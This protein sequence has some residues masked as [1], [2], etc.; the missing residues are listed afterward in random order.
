MFFFFLIRL[1]LFWRKLLILIILVVSLSI[2]LHKQA[3]L[4]LLW[5]KFFVDA[6]KKTLLWIEGCWHIVLI[7]LYQYSENTFFWGQLS[8]DFQVQCFKLCPTKKLRFR[9]CVS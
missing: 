8:V 6:P 1:S 2:I 9:K 7:N 3:D 5:N 4:R